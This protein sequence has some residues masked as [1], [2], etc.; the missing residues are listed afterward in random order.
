M[1]TPSEH[2]QFEIPNALSIGMSENGLTRLSITNG[3]AEAE[4]YLHGGHLTHFQPKGEA[5][6]IFDA[7]ESSIMPPKSVHA[8]IP[9]CWPWFGTHPDDS[10]KPQHGFA[11]DKVWTLHR[12][13]VLANGATEVVLT[14]EDDAETKTLFPYAF[15]LEL[16]FTIGTT[17]RID[18]KTTNTD[19]SS[20]TV[21]QA[22]HTY[23]AVSD[24]ADV[25]IEGVSGTPFVDYTDDKK[26]KSE[27]DVLTITREV[28]RVYIPTD[29]TCK[30]ID[31][32]LE[33]TIVVE[34]SGSNSTTIWNPWKENGLHDLP[35]DKYRK[36]VCIETVNALSDKVTLASQE[37]HTI[38]QTI[39]VER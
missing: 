4:I 22:L 35:N 19:N 25:Y 30:I 23:F 11:R 15:E 3:S 2:K 28:N 1:Q 18:L 39:A 14:L 9:I 31:K 21:T 16:T 32:G 29:A 33:R 20:F 37:S 27:K 10:T 24:I 34:K 17:L 7:K 38:S 5:A 8:G 13:A 12:T 26:E 36:F 6:L